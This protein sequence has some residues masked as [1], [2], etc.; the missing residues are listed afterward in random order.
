MHDSNM[1]DSQFMR[2]QDNQQKKMSNYID[3]FDNENRV[4]LMNMLY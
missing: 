1:S 4:K 2:F 3:D